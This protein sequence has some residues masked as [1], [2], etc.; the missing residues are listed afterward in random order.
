MSP[1]RHGPD[2][3]HADA[4]VVGAGFG[5]LGA[6]LTLAAAGKKVVLCEALNYPGGCASTFQRNGLRYEAGATLF[7]GFGEG[8]LFSRWVHR[9]HMKVEWEQHDPVMTFTAAGRTHIVPASQQAWVET[10]VQQSPEHAQGIRS[11]FQSIQRGSDALWNLID[12]DALTT[13]RAAREVLNLGNHLSWMR[14]AGRPLTAVARHHGVESVQPL[15]AWL[16]AICQI[17]VQAAASQAEAP[18]G[19]AACTFPFRGVATVKGGIGRFATELVRAIE[20][21][22]GEVRFSNAIYRVT[23]NPDKTW[24]VQGRGAAIDAPCVVLNALPA[25]AS[26]LLGRPVLPQLQD[27]LEGGWGAVMLYLT[28]ADQPDFPDGSAHHQVYL[29]P[30]KAPIEG[31]AALVTL[32]ERQLGSEGPIRT[33]TVSTHF[34]MSRDADDTPKAVE[35][36]QQTLRALVKATFPTWKITHEMPA[37]PRTFQRFTQRS[38]GLVGG[39]PRRVGLRQYLEP[40]RRPI[41]DGLYLV[42]DSVFLGQSTLAAAVGGQWVASSILGRR[43]PKDSFHKHAIDPEVSEGKAKSSGN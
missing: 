27:K 13:R 30:H 18:F 43:H 1:P 25:G 37:S 14:W 40:F 29:D 39:V 7:S 12:E 36:I 24:R 32:G 34:Q 38:G 22:G 33:A 35:Q 11:F 42:G 26:K 20:R 15:R 4:V 28:V 8:Q 5:G 23:R 41:D 21:A 3:T 16:D 6:A 10:L 19:M 31:N 17:T 9:H 2:A